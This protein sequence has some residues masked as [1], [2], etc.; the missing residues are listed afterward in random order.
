MTTAARPTF[1][2]AKGGTGLHDK[3]LGK[4]TQSKS[5]RDQPANLRL[6]ERVVGQDTA[7]ELEG[8]DFEAELEAR[9]KAVLGIR[10]SKSSHHNNKDTP[11]AIEY[12]DDI[13]QTSSYHRKSRTIYRDDQ[14]IYSELNTPLGHRKSEKNSPLRDQ[15][16][17]L[18]DGHV[19][20]EDVDDDD[21][22]GVCEGNKKLDKDNQ[23]DLDDD[24]DDDDDDEEDDE[25]DDVDPA[26]LLA[27]LEKIKKERALEKEKKEQEQLKKQEKL[28]S[29]SSSSRGPSSFVL[30]RPWDDDIPFKH[31]S[32]GYDDKKKP[33]YV[34]DTLRSDSHKKFMDK[35]IR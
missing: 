15:S 32:R 25:E 7:E 6:K 11:K 16:P 18:Q 5:S 12:R 27:E 20:Q 2:P 19:D 29:N 34:N 8:R 9:E 10:G 14:S 24:Y 35:Y 21:D 13:S 33:D 3:G 31:C 23:S 22:D 1:D 4:V 17:N 26:A 28:I 30:K